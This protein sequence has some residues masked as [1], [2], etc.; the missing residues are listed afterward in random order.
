MVAQPSPLDDFWEASSLHAGNAASFAARLDAFDR[1]PEPIHPFT[2]PG[3]PVPLRPVRDRLQRTM[4]ARRSTRTFSDRAFRA[5][6][7]ARLLAAV[8]PGREG[9]RVVPEAGALSCVHVDVLARLADPPWS[10]RV[11]RYDH[12][13]HAISDVGPLPDDRELTRLTM[14][15]GPM[16]ALFLV[17]VVDLRAGRAKY[18]DRAGRFALQQVGH[19]AQN[20]GLRIAAEGWAGVVLG[21]GLDAEILSLLR[22]HHTEARYVGAMAVGR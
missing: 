6:D 16:P 17:F 13:R 14:W 8:G 7:L 1:A 12:V 5:S 4:E 20:L 2:A 11:V 21:G 19:A 22:L 3:A 10:R 9:R 18:G 15:G